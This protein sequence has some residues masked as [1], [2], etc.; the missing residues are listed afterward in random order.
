MM[1]PAASRRRRR[2]GSPAWRS[3]SNSRSVGGDALISFCRP[4]RS[5]TATNRALH[6]HRLQVGLRRPAGRA[7]LSRSP[8]LGGGNSGTGSRRTA[9]NRLVNM[10]RKV[11][12][13]LPPEILIA[14][15]L[16]RQH[17]TSEREGKAFTIEAYIITAVVIIKDL[18]SGNRHITDNVEMLNG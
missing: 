9:L 7:I 1:T 14:N 13:P 11:N 8:I 5:T 10:H 12:R 2:A 4:G 6:N 15:R 16:A 17:P 18:Y 3:Y